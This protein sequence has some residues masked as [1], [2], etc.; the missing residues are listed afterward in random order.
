[1]T[2]A[3]LSLASL[4]AGTETIA[5]TAITKYS[6]N[7]NIIYMAVAILLYGLV[8]PLSVYYSLSYSSIGTVNFTWNIITTVSMIVIGKLLFNDNVTH[9]HLI[10]LLMGISSMVILYIAEME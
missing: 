7:K 4:L 2:I 9:L 6:R 10:S 3:L 8:I 1:M 5:M